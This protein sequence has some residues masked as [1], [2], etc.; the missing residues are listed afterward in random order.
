[1][2]LEELLTRYKDIVASKDEV[3]EEDASYLSFIEMCLELEINRGSKKVCNCNCIPFI[4]VGAKKHICY[5]SS[6]I[7]RKSQG[8]SLQ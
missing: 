5:N 1:M 4:L 2:T 7:N 3:S 6:Y 8:M